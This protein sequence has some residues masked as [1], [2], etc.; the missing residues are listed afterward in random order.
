MKDDTLIKVDCR[1]R[2]PVDTWELELINEKL[3]DIYD[4]YAKRYRFVQLEL[5][6]REE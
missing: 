3:M 2:Q 5:I 4:A 6:I 1:N